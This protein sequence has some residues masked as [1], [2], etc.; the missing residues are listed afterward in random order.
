MRRGGGAGTGE[1]MAADEERWTRAASTS[2]AG[3]GFTVAG[4]IA[5]VTGAGSGI[6]AALAAAL[7]DRDA[8]VVLLADLDGDAATSTADSLRRSGSTEVIPVA[9]DV[10]DATALRALI[11][12][13]ESEH[14]RLDL[15]CS[16]AGIGTGAGVD[17]P[18]A[19]WQ[20]AWDVNL[21][22]HVHA[23]DAALPGM[24]DRGEGALLH[25]CSAAGLLTVAG[26]A[27]YAVTKHAAVAFAEWLALT[28]GDRGITVTALCPLG[29]ETGMLA[30]ED[31][32]ATRFVR[33]TGR[34]LAPA[35]VAD[36]ALDALAAGEMLALPHPEVAA[37][38]Q[39]RAVDRRTWLARL[40]A[41]VAALPAGGS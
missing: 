20:R 26:D 5:L 4:R 29:V 18:V 38:E 3:V 2:G 9:L 19:L 7:V 16:N 25:T 23:A 24:L 37:M 41:A 33:G 36:A 1:T 11:A 10:A 30:A 39:A 35:A 12:R 31:L 22:A 34:V 15:V 8:A 13:I 17:A 6:G 27:P 40:R 21:M 14:G 32:L 28:Y